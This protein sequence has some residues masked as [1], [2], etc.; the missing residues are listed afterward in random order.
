M[1]KETKVTLFHFIVWLLIVPPGITFL[2]ATQMPKTVSPLYVTLFVLFG[3]LTVL[4]PIKKNGN[5]VTLLMWITLPSFLLYGLVI[6]VIVMQLSILGALISSKNRQQTIQRFFVNSTMMFILSFASAAAFH[7]VG[8]QIGSL[9]FWPML[10]S[11]IVYRLTYTTT[12]LGFIQ[13]YMRLRKMKFPFSAKEIGDE[14]ATTV[15]ILP[16]ALS[17]YFMLQIVG[18]GTFL[19]M[20]L[21]F[22]CTIGMIRMY[23][24]S[25][26]VNGLLENA[27][28]IGTE[29]SLLTDKKRVTEQFV[30][31]TCKLFNA[32]SVLFFKN[33]EGWLELEIAFA[34]DRFV[35][36]HYGSI[37]VGEGVVGK[38]LE[39]NEPVIYSKRKEW[40]KF[41]TEFVPMELESMLCIPL[42][43]NG[44]TI[45][46]L[47]LGSNRRNA[48]KDYQ[49]KVLE[50][51]GSYYI[52]AHEK[53]GYVHDAKVKSE[54]CALTNLYNYRYL[55]EQ[56]RIEMDRIHTKEL[57]QLSLVMLD[58]DRFK[59]VNDTYGHQSG[60]DILCQL[61]R[62]LEEEIPPNSTV[63]RYGGEEFVFILPNFSKQEATEYAHDLRHRIKKHPFTIKPDLA[64][65]KQTC[66]L[67]ITTSI[68]VSNAPTDTDDAI[69]L[70]RNADRALYIGAKQS[71]RD[72]VAVYSK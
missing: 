41:A 61:A 51:I 45:G 30:Q 55:E 65:D 52:V 72:K 1:S 14:Y 59:G 67:F 11:V 69:S 9:E 16:L 71:G 24:Q 3:L 7:L 44:L 35:D 49:L 29:L 18:I 58:I 6:E 2:L 20:G 57:E 47:S 22:F 26:K 28:S 53:S 46:V 39:T 27:G 43:H 15:L 63:G 54:R 38:V 25:E 37:P 10:L 66:E 33:Y 34:K 21:P 64:Q 50:L 60:N 8:G 70:L 42:S 19:L 13:L 40:Q 31:Q 17:L 4:F 36:L 48:F 5:T 62:I 68:G 32:D 23:S 56:L 12:N